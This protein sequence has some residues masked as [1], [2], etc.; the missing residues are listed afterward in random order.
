MKLSSTAGSPRF[1]SPKSARS[2]ESISSPRADFFSRKALVPVQ[3]PMAVLNSFDL[4]SRTMTST[5]G[6]GYPSSSSF[7]SLREKPSRLLSPSK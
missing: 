3:S 4:S 2:W 7:R 6:P 5:F 1:S